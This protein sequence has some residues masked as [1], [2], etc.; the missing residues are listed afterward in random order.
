[1]RDHAIAS[2]RFWT[3]ETGKLLRRLGHAH[4]VVA[5]Y[6]FTCPSSNMIGL[7]YLPLP[8]LCHEVGN[9]DAEGASEVLR[10]LS[11]GGF[12]YYDEVSEFVY[13]PAMASIQVGDRLSPGD[14]RCIGV[15]RLLEQARKTPFFKHFVDRYD[16][17]Y[18]LKRHLESAPETVDHPSPLQAP[19]K[20]GS[21][22]GSGP[23]IHERARAPEPQAPE[24][25]TPPAR[26]PL[27]VEA[28]NT[29]FEQIR[30]AYPKFNGRQDWVQAEH[31]CNVRV[32][33]EGETWTGLLEAVQRYAR[34]V[35]AGGVSSPQY[36]MT[37]GK[38]FSASDQPW[39]NP[40]DLPPPKATSREQQ[41]QRARVEREENER[42]ELDQLRESR[43]ANGVPDF[44]DPHPGESPDV[45]RTALAL[46]VREAHGGRRVLNV[47]TSL[48]SAK[49]IQ[50]TKGAA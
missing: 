47:V 7:Y 6:L 20:P 13:I 15:A 8:T 49:T 1:M 10:S 34:Y 45:Y 48:A 18:H 44:R 16:A 30:A 19:P 28:G 41:H 42:V 43:A 25:A 9:L 38:F 17:A 26:R 36:V 5:F 46:A 4:Q 14:K 27:L 50:T 23:G 40:W 21:G 29:P 32:D 37:P 3:G 24:P 11:E 12:A 33:M 22:P 39:H 31:Y 2:P 35:A